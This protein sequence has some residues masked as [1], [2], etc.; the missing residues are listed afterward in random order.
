[1]DLND[2]EA[3]AY[4]FE[5][6]TMTQGD[7]DVMVSLYDVGTPLGLE[8]ADAA[9]IAEAL[10]IQGYAEMK[11]LSGGIGITDQG[12]EVL[13][14]KVSPKSGGKD[15]ELGIGPTL[16]DQGRKNVETLIQDIQSAIPGMTL[17]YQHLEE[18]VMDIKTIEVQMLS[19]L[20]KVSI[21]REVLR[22]LQQSLISMGAD[23]LNI[24]LTAL[25]E[26]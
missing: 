25:I 14:I 17:P 10:F 3:K 19:P 23:E 11:T 7:T 15:L 6:Y 13:E 18:I 24:K 8:K 12:L 26:S 1:M 16:E 2:P 4:L 20:P 21:I 9:R 22:S 5:L